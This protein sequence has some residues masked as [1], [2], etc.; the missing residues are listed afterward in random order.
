M[1]LHH[2]ADPRKGPDTPGCPQNKWLDQIRDDSAHPIGDPW[3]RAVGRGHGG[4]STR[5][6][7]PA[8]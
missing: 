3:K 2:L 7:S 5:Q 6:P 4:A 8:T 1:L